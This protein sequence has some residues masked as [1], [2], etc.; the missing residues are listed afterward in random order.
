MSPFYQATPQMRHPSCVAPGAAAL[1][2]ASQGVQRGMV[3]GAFNAPAPSAFGASQM[4][5]GY[6]AATPGPYRAPAQMH[7]QGATMMPAACPSTAYASA[8]RMPPSN[9]VCQGGGKDGIVLCI[10][11]SLTAGVKNTPNAYPANLDALLKQKGYEFTFKNEGVYAET[12]DILL[13]RI[14]QA[15]ANVSRLGPIRFIF[16]LTGTNDILQFRSPE[17]IVANLRRIHDMAAAAPGSPHVVALTVPQSRLF[18]PQQ[19]DMRS[20]VN[21]SI[22]QI[23]Q[24]ARGPRPRFVVDLETVNVDLAEDGVHYVGQGYKEFAQLADAA[25]GN[26]LEAPK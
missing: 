21:A 8:P 1:A 19:E 16:I 10:G 4:A 24:Q 23:S 2:F 9:N 20:M 15:I 14:Q 6:S 7:G 18:R 13:R 3:G 25:M 11:D 5:H 12:S 17:S 26:F 22:K